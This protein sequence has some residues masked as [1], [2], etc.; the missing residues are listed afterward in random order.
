[1]QDYAWL[2]GFGE[3]RE[4]AAARVGVTERHARYVYEP[5]LAAMEAAARGDAA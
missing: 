3:S 5:M 2:T 1:V 4:Q